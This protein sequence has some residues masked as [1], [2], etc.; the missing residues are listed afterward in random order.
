MCETWSFAQNR[1]I[2]LHV[3]APVGLSEY[4]VR[5]PNNL[6]ARRALRFRPSSHFDARSASD[7]KIRVAKCG[8]LAHTA[9]DMSDVLVM[10]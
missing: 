9:S 6:M 5:C 10:A 8:M 3:G 4:L 7:E 2:N 1:A